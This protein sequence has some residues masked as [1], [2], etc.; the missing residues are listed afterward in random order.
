MHKR[1][2]DSQFLMALRGV[3]CSALCS[4]IEE[5]GVASRFDMCV[6]ASRFEMCVVSLR[7][8]WWQGSCLAMKFLLAMR[9]CC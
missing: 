1:A 8:V 4:D 3:Q 2:G 9:S 6:V 7:C 5:S